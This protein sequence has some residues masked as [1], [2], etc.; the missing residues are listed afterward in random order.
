[1]Q[2]RRDNLED[3]LLLY[4]Y[5]RDVDDEMQWLLEKEPLA[6]STDLGNSLT[7][8]QSLQKKHQ[9]LETELASREPVVSALASRAKQMSRSAHFAAARIEGA[10]SALQDKLASLRNAASVRRLRLLDALESQMVRIVNTY[11][12]FYTAHAWGHSFI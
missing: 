7:A 3:A 11:T 2:I 1:M 12:S 10:T 4:Q 5:L 6:V 8:V 9:A